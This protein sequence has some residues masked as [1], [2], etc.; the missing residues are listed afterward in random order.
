MKQLIKLSYF[1]FLVALSASAHGQMAG[2]SFKREIK[3]VSDQWHK[4][5]LPDVLFGKATQR[6]TDLRIFGL[7]A[8][9]DTLEAPYLL[10]VSTEKTSSKAVAF[11][12]LNV[13][14]NAK[15]HYFT[16]EIP[17]QESI[18]QIKLDFAQDN[19]DWRVTLEGSQDQKEWFT[20][21]ENYRILS[22]KNDLTDFQFT[23]LNFPNTKYRF[24]RVRIDS[25]V[26]PE[27]NVAS[28]TQNDIVEGSFTKYNVKKF[29]VT[30]H[31]EKKQTEI[32]V[33][34]DMPSRLSHLKIGVSASYD[35]YRPVTIKYLSD[36][37]ETEQGWKYNYRRLASGTLNS[38]ENNEFACGSKTVQKLKIIIHNHDNQPLTI[39]GIE[40]KGYVHELVARF[41]EQATY[42]LTYGNKSATKPNYDIER[43]T[44]NIP[45]T[46]STL[47][48]GQELA[49][50]KEAVAETEPFFKNKAWLW[51]IMIVIIALLGWFSV[52]MMREK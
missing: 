23:K 37:V 30:E 1:L 33:E 19:F 45:E 11:K 14:H 6:L 26:K 7:T 24:F 43:F 25:K 21:A 22:I 15:G 27:L 41:T 3:G 31:K 48:L 28:I 47:E 4:I 51:A 52:S 32:G 38:I 9:N 20:V 8:S 5:A 44:A 35:F 16:F 40:A 42:Y 10:R 50:E 46:L 36:S 34:L 2:Y 39:D 49:T 13:S 29:E 17:T 12:T 18:N